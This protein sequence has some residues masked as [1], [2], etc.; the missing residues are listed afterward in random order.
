M[1]KDQPT[2]ESEA[3]PMI[4]ASTSVFGTEQSLHWS[5]DPWT[6]K[7]E[8]IPNVYYGDRIRNHIGFT[9]GVRILDFGCG[10][11]LVT[12]G[13]AAYL[14]PRQ[15][16]AVDIEDYIDHPENREAC[17]KRGF[18]YE[19]VISNISYQ[20][21]RPLQSHGTE[22]YDA[23]VSW[24]VIEHIPSETIAE[25]FEIL[26]KA[27]RPGGI[28]V[29]QSA[30]LYY[31]PFGSHVYKLDP[32][33]HLGLSECISRERIHASHSDRI[34]AKACIECLETLNRCTHTDFRVAL[35]KAGFII[36][37][38]YTS[39][40]NLIPSDRLKRILHE[41]TLITEQVL[42]ALTKA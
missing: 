6:E 37:E 26:Y 9:Q 14:S 8:R 20:T 29:L 19:D 36:I 18:I 7:F 25:E 2:H 27:L 41:E 34:E 33:F 39:N 24:S 40:T 22:I 17:S 31:S 4:A 42:F 12:T 30:P 10:S 21:R 23:I 35:L 32:W 1:N 3:S 38:E 11:G 5:A 13:L 15:I 28:A 16:D